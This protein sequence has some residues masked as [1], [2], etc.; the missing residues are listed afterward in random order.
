MPP[1]G[2]PGRGTPVVLRPVPARAGGPLARGGGPAGGHGRRRGAVSR[3][4]HAG[5]K[6]RGPLV[7]TLGTT[8]RGPAERLRRRGLLLAA[9]TIGWNLVEA[10]AAAMTRTA[11]AAPCV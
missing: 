6:P 2:V 5:S 10:V 7:T 4:R 3:L 1:G 11:S 9:V 8:A